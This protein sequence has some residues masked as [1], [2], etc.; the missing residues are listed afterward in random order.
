M[1][2]IIHAFQMAWYFGRASHTAM[3]VW[4]KCETNISM[5]PLNQIT[6]QRPRRSARSYPSN[7]VRSGHIPIIRSKQTMHQ[8]GRIAHTQRN[9]INTTF[10]MVTVAGMF[11]SFNKL[12]NQSSIV[13]RKSLCFFCLS[14]IVI[15]NA[16]DRRRGHTFHSI[17]PKF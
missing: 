16:S 2:W 17:I 13:K 3:N 6:E 12:I 9:L 10:F 5:C 15:S 8:L 14:S 11:E 7:W 4:N 1:Q